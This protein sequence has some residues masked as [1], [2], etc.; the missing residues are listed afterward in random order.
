VK[1]SSLHSCNVLEVTPEARHLWR[2][3]VGDGEVT[4]STEQRTIL[5]DPLPAK[6]V[7][8]DWRTLWQRKLNIA[9][10]PADQVFLRVVHLPAS[11]FPEL[12]SMV[13]FQLEKLSPVPVNQIV[14]SVELLPHHLENMQA[15]VVIIAAR[16]MVE[17]FLGKLE[18]DGYQPDRLELPYLHQLLT[19]RMEEN[20]L[21]IYPSF[22]GGKHRCLVA[23]W[24]GG[25]LQ[26]LQLLHLPD[27]ANRGTLL[28]EQLTKAAWAG[29]M[30]GWLSAP[31]RLHLVADEAAAALWEPSLSLWTGQN[32]DVTTPLS[33]GAVAE[34]AAKRAARNETKANLLPSEFGARYQQQ[35]IDRLW[36]SGLGAV[37]ATYVLGVAIYFGALQVL[38]YQQHRVEKQVTSISNQYTNAVKLKERVEV[39]QSQLNLKYAALESLRVASEELR[40]SL[41]LTHFHF[42]KGKKVFLEGTAPQEEVGEV[43]DYNSRLRTVRVNGT[44]LFSKVEVPTTITRNQTLTWRFLCDLNRGELE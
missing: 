35:F 38:L 18:N 30:E 23:W 3:S 15:V 32:V 17:A 37:L 19:T 31:M 28:V 4:L 11:D 14:W 10:L 12:L 27:S 36:M 2:F 34:L 9:W 8:K 7:A 20:G 44:L 5:P 22:E 43:T 1:N 13:E 39:L 42:Q 24:F 26:Q 16:N 33:K 29:E 21:W 6:L 25:A 41:T 40:G